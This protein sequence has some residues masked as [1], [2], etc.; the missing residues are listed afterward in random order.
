MSDDLSKIKSKISKLLAMA[1]GTSNDNEAMAFMAKAEALLD[2]YQLSIYECGDVG[3]P[4]GKTDRFETGNGSTPTWRKHL[5]HALARYYGCDL[6]RMWPRDT[7]GK[8][9]LN[10]VGRESSRITVQLMF[11]FVIEQ[12]RA[13][14][15]KLAKRTGNTVDREV[16]SIATEVSARIWK[17]LREAKR[18][19]QDAN[20]NAKLDS[21]ALVVV[22]EMKAY[23]ADVY[24]SLKISAARAKTTT[25]GARDAAAGISINRQMSGAGQL[26]I[27]NR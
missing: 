16:R 3:D 26:R 8:F 5:L 17:L 18:Q 11:P 13:E 10:I 23:I 27:G 22:E 1:H 20:V 2:E 25:H 21:R 24:G 14:G 6:I 19:G 7:P 9:D 15:R 4:M 12:I